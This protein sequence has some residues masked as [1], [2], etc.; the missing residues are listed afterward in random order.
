[1]RSR[2][3]PTAE[4]IRLW[5][6]DAESQEPAQD[7]DLTLATVAYD[8]LFMQLAGDDA[9]PK[10]DYFLA[11]LYLIV[12]DAVRTGYRTKAKED[13]EALLKKAEVRFPKRPVYLWTQRSRELLQH[14]ERFKYDEW[15]AG[16]LAREKRA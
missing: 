13:V 15:C 9:C 12:G 6:F 10:R 1:M 14:P 3:N 7:W 2:F 5:A 16:G 4:D 8:D 11:L